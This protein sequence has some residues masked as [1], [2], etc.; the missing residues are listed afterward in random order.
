MFAR[1]RVGE[2]KKVLGVRGVPVLQN[3]NDG[4]DK[5]GM[6]EEGRKANRGQIADGT[7]AW[8]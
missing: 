3:S 5:M 7:S 4:G 2:K 1:W 6:Q 8:I